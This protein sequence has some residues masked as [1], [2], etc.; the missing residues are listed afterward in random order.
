[1]DERSTN[2]HSQKYCGNA[3]NE[4]IEFY[5]HN[6]SEQDKKE[7][8]NVLDSIFLTTGT[9]VNQFEQKFARYTGNKF[10]V[11]VMSCTHALELAL[12]YFNIGANDEIITTPLSFSATS[13]VIEYVGANTVFVDVETE[14]G[15]I[16]AN[17]IEAAITP[18]TR[19]IIVVHL[20]GHMCNMIKIKEI[21]D[22][23]NLKIIEDAAHCVEGSRDGI[24][25]G[26]LGDMAAYSFYATKNLTCGEGGAIT[27][28]DVNMYEW[29][30]MAR[31]HG[32][33]KNA[34][35][36]YTKK[37]EHY[38]MKFLGLKCN[39]SNIQAALL[40]NQIDGLDSRLME[41]E[42]ICKLYDKG[43]QNNKN[44]TVLK[45]LPLTRHARHLY[46]IL[47]DTGRRDQI[48]HALQDAK[49]GVAVNY[50]PIHELSYYKNKYG[51]TPNMFP[52]AKEI[53]EKTISIPLYP[54][55]NFSEIEYIIE[56]VN[57]VSR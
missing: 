19:A 12:R 9:T 49:I 31:S 6:L 50:R 35:D 18:N 36:R 21:A 45:T 5:K 57:K 54:S 32:I 48:L 51:F 13:N 27:C 52:V 17:K 2:L 37:Y 40:L 39:M 1:M 53:G 10:A 25:V 55:L 56:T 7:L 47:V 14:T 33:T 41:R 8:L 11:G 46:T 43:F 26:Q 44:V 34:A 20:Y 4:K 29:L 15:N 3:L 28:N 30:M 38:D 22:K 16:D 24:H 42:T 23:Y